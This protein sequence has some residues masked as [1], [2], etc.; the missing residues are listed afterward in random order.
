VLITCPTFLILDVVGNFMTM[1]KIV[2]IIKVQ[3]TDKFEGTVTFDVD[4]RQYVAFYWGDNF[5]V[6]EKVNVTLTQLEH[7]FGYT[8]L[9]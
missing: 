4:G 8:G 9:S 3:E 5:R 2:E 7:P 1:N 6:G